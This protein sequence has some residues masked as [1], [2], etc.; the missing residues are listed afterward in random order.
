MEREEAVY[1]AKLA[2]QV[3]LGGVLEDT[4]TFVVRRRVK[5]KKSNLGSFSPSKGATKEVQL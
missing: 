3:R 5:H 1:M 4:C 2:E